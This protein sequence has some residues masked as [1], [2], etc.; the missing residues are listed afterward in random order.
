MEK[1][2]GSRYLLISDN[3]PVPQIAFGRAQQTLS[4]LLNRHGGLFPEI[5]LGLE[6][7]LGVRMDTLLKTQAAWDVAE[8]RKREGGSILGGLW[9]LEGNFVG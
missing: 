6:K 1:V 4:I 8:A 7:A 3:F 2:Y 9:R 5:A